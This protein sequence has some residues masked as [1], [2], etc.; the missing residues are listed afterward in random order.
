MSEKIIKNISDIMKKN[1]WGSKMDG[2]SKSILK[3]AA[4]IT[5]IFVF[6]SLYWHGAETQL[7]LINTD[8]TSTD[9]R[10]Y[11][12]YA[13]QLHETNYTYIGDHNRMPIYPAIQS[14]FYQIDMPNELFFKQGKYLNLYLS[15]GILFILLFIFRNF[16]SWL[17]SFTL[18]TIVAFTVFMFKAGY[19][20]T[21]LL[22]YFANFGLFLLMTTLIKR[23]S[24]RTA[25]L[26]GIAA[27]LTHLIKASILPGLMLFLVIASIKWIILWYNKRR[28]STQNTSPKITI[29]HLLSIPLVGLVFLLTVFPYIS[30]SKSI[31]GQ[32]FYNV[33]STFYIWYDSWAEAREG[34][35]AHG[36]RVGWPD[37]P[38]TE[39]PSMSNYLRGHTTTQIVARFVN[40]GK[41]LLT[42]VKNSYGYF[43]YVLI[44]MGLFTL[45]I[46]HSRQQMRSIV[47]ANPFLCLFLV[48]YFAGYFL[49]YA[50]YVP[51]SSGNRFILAQFLPLI[52]TLSWG[53]MTLLR[54]SYINLG[55]LSIPTIRI[56]NL[57]L[58]LVLI[59]DLHFYLLERV[60]VMYGGS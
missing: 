55:G 11:M 59:V 37:M 30:T 22:F 35:R 57:A 32:Y 49:L 16:F 10:A 2:Q 43:N 29:I 15:F 54:S 13:T 21:E 25:I 20:Q 7:T 3:F 1:I 9:Q 53:I 4:I 44:L 31:F 38:S 19:F 42:K 41:D 51:I 48:L 40:G 47:K 52:F 58:L 23:L 60:T 34:T 8:M 12:N 46:Y 45:A 5:I 28:T 18:L 56:A 39:I 6:V 26:T 33:N 14:L 17:H 24:W 27:G 36:D 50:W